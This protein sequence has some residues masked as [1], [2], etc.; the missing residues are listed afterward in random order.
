M[1]KKQEKD[2]RLRL[3]GMP[4]KW[5]DMALDLIYRKDIELQGM[6]LILSG[7]REYQRFLANPWIEEVLGSDPMKALE[8]IE[9]GKRLVRSIRV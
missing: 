4:K 5:Q 6:G 7:R 8:E 9:K 3:A 2:Y 1:T